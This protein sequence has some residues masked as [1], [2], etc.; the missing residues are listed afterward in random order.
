MKSFFIILLL[1]SQTI[2]SPNILFVDN[3]AANTGQGTFAEPFKSIQE[4]FSQAQE[5]DTIYIRGSVQPTPQIYDEDLSLS[6]SLA[7][8]E[9]EHPIV[10]RA[11]QE[12]KVKI[13]PQSSFSIYTA[14]WTFENL[15][16]D[17]GGKAY[18]LIKLR[19]DHITFRRC[20]LTNGQKDGIDANNASNML[21]ENCTIHNFVRSDQYDAHGIILNGGVDNVIRNNTIYDCKG[22]CIQLYKEDQNY[23]TLIE[24]ND[25]Y[26]TLGP[27][28]ENAIDVKAARNL[29][30]RNNKMHGFHRA[31]DSDGVALKINKDTDNTLV[32]GNDIFESNGGIRVTGGDVDSIRIERNVIHDL[33]V[34]E[35]DSS[36]YGYGIQMD[37][38]NAI[39]LINNTF[40]NIPG[41]LFWIASRGADGFTMENNLFY[42][43]NTFKGDTDDLQNIVLIDYNGWFQ[44]AQTIPGEHDV[45]GDDPKFADPADYDYRLL[46]NSPAID[47]GDPSFGTNFPGERIDLGAFEFEP[48][49]GVNESKPIFPEGAQLLK[50]YPNPFNPQ[51]TLEF[52]L[53]SQAYVRLE[54]FNILGEKIDTVLSALQAAG[55]H[56]IRW[57]AH[58]LPAGIYFARLQ[59]NAQNTVQSLVLLK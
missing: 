46:E 3:Q 56:R 12:E 25:L 51:T 28:S 39:Q 37:G 21:I 53:N 11:Y 33:H 35:G 18:D 16:F 40:A 30:I 44:C 59:T 2:C 23:G 19:G 50:A 7:S 31:E 8:G 57:R 22:D 38:V 13:I 55:V 41:P 14:Y 45:T 5:G 54:I 17:M 52:H 42:K 4:A 26:T 27:N 58:D 48:S 6:S 36:K 20:E 47:K 10:V 49:T 15:I 34:D 1:V 24:G 32:Y 29:T 9:K 43:A